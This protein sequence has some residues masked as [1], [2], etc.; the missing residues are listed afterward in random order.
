MIIPIRCFTCN[1]VI[2][3]KWDT[4]NQMKQDGKDS[5]TI[6]KQIGLK[7]FCCKR[8]MMTTYD[9]TDHEHPRRQCP[10]TL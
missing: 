5:D 3:N 2:A 4:Y 8:M 1:K 9:I 6:F 10:Q 7:R